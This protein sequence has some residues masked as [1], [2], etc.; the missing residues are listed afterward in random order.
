MRFLCRSITISMLFLTA[1]FV[2]ACEDQPDPTYSVSFETNGGPAIETVTGLEKGERLSLEEPDRPGYIFLGWEDDEENVHLDTITVEDDL[3]L[4]AAYERIEDVF[5]YDTRENE[6]YDD[7]IS[8][9]SYT[10][11]ARRLRVPKTIDE[12]LVTGIRAE[13]F[14]D[15]PIEDLILP[16]SALSLSFYAFAYAPD[17]DTLSFY[18]DYA[19]YREKFIASS[20]YEDIL[21][22]HEDACAIVEEDPMTEYKRFE[23]GCPIH[24]TLSKTDPVTIPGEEDPL[25]GYEVVVDLAYYEEAISVSNSW[26]SNVFS[27]S[28]LREIVVPKEMINISSLAFLDTEN[29]EAIIVE[30][31]NAQYRSEDGILY[32]RSDESLFFYPPA[33]TDSDFMLPLNVENVGT[34]AFKVAHNPYLENISVPSEHAHFTSFDGV[35]Y[36]EDEQT[37]RVYPSGRRDSSYT[38]NDTATTIEAYAFRSATHLETVTLPEGLKEIGAR[39]FHMSGLE[40]V[41]IPDSVDLIG[42]QALYDIDTLETVVFERELSEENPLIL[43]GSWLAFDDGVTVYVPDNSYDSYLELENFGYMGSDV[44]RPLSELTA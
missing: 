19:G 30:E 9:R 20:S 39:A 36:D 28:T 35:L 2:Q 17:L 21:S 22:E 25:Y 8:I 10:G 4:Y 18:G 1:L 42:S 44:I 6:N 27:A 14:T 37:L 13:A 11:D 32:N 34:D 29:L 43:S 40:H 5:T 24:R 38:V 23:T 41:T 16:R 7:E 12:K 26:S 3:I 31:D 15:T 33:K